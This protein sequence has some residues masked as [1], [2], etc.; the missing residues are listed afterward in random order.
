MNVCNSSTGK[1]KTCKL[2][3]VEDKCNPIIVLNDSIALQLLNVNVPFTDKWTGNVHSKRSNSRYDE[4]ETEEN[5]QQKGHLT[6]DY[7]SKKYAKLFKGIGRFQCTPAKIQL[8]SNAV[9]VQKPARRIPV[10][11]KDEFQNEINTMVKDGI[12]TKLGKNQATEW[13]NSF[14]VVRKPSGKLRICLDP[15]DLNPHIRPVCNSNTLD[16]VVHKLRKAKYF[17]VFDAI[18]GF[19]HVPLDDRSRLLTTMLTPLGVFIYNVLVMG[20]SN[21][22]D[23]FEQCL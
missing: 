3:M 20:L 21:A 7:I 14:V 12:L 5:G 18:R 1:S 4:M 9:S 15:T 23:I 6:H 16:D 11:L 17:A 13:L 10:A 22:N 19:F 8:K 2:F